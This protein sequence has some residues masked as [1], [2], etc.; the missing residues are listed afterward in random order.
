MK[1]ILIPASWFHTPATPFNGDFI[2]RIADS[3]ASQ[4]SITLVHIHNNSEAKTV[5]VNKEIVN[6]NYR[7]YIVA[8]PA[9]AK[10]KNFLFFQYSI[11]VFDQIVKEHGRPDWAHV[12]V[13]WKMGFMALVLKYF[14]GV[15]YVVTEHWTGYLPAHY[16]LHS[17][18]KFLLTKFILSRSKG[19]ATVSENLGKQICKLNLARQFTVLPNVVL[20]DSGKKTENTSFSFVHFSN[21]RDIQKNVS[22]IVRAFAEA[23]KSGCRANLILGG[24]GLESNNI[25]LLAQE[26]GLPPDRFEIMQHQTHHKTLEIINSSLAL[27]TFSRFETFSITCA[28]A[29]CMGVPVVYT[30]CGG[31]EEYLDTQMGISVPINDE[32]ALTH[33][34]LSISEGWI[35]FDREAIKK[36]AQDMFSKEM[37][38]KKHISFYE[39]A[40]LAAKQ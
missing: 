27:I 16:Q 12:Q 10:N 37:F 20:F 35:N 30:P 34:M 5:V 15:A 18:F 21:F 25:A 23:I 36:K 19:L 9:S 40:G 31:P 6:P 29:A 14:R 17:K 32:K 8:I 38:L 7:K 28:E 11:R 13:V 22:G 26:L 33:A 1:H 4:F 39:K 3:L 2:E 24:D